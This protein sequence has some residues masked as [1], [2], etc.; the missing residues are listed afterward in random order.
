M[1]RSRPHGGR[2]ERRALGGQG[3]SRPRQTGHHGP[4][5]SGRWMERGE[6][7]LRARAPPG[8][9][10]KD[11]EEGEGPWEGP[12]PLQGGARADDGAG[13]GGAGAGALPALAPES[14][15]PAGGAQLQPG[16]PGA[17]GPGARPPLVP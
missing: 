3:A 9:V 8:W 14:R 2:P 6:G 12:A 17:C 10:G 16:D 11:P 4:P 7:R 13:E 1:G 5:A 15:P